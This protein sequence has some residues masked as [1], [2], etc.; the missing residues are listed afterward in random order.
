MPGILGQHV[1]ETIAA[2]ILIVLFDGGNIGTHI[3]LIARKP[4]DRIDVHVP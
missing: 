1:V 2:D 3:T 4:E